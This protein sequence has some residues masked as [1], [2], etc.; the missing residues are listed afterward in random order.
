MIRGRIDAVVCDMDGVLYRGEL[1]VD[2]AAAAIAKLRANGTI[3]LFCTNNSRWTRQH[4][5]DRLAGLGIPCTPDDVLTSAA[6]TGDVL[7][8][9]GMAGRRAFVIGGDGLRE[10]VRT[11]GLTAA[12][13]PP[14]DAVVVGWDPAFDYEAMAGAAQAV[15]DGAVFVASNDDASYPAP[16]GLLPGA[17]AILASIEKA[18]GR[19]AQVV[20]KPNAPMLDAIARRLEP[21]ATVVAIGD[22]PETDLAGAHERGW[23]TALV[24]SGVT[25]VETAAALLPPPD[26]VS[27]SISELVDELI[28]R[29]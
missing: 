25:N 12:A 24:L 9:M 10:E 29:Q 28:A 8:R 5:I 1:P 22:R 6:V 15:M 2:G 7:G 20:G 27:P 11:A 4:H 14:I 18:S 19:R 3:V 23:G 16:D 17:G 26:L 21:A 13:A